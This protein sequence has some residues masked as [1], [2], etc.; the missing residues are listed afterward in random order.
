MALLF[1]RH[2]GSLNLG[3]RSHELF[4]LVDREIQ[5]L[6]DERK[7]NREE[8]NKDR[9]LILPVLVKPSFASVVVAWIR[10]E[11]NHLF[12]AIFLADGEAHQAD[13]LLWIFHADK[14]VHSVHDG[15]H[16]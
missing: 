11:I 9:D 8:A 15:F 7:S 5:S 6:F 2:D 10:Q 3:H 12:Y 13:W 4:E 1:E 14:L 16:L